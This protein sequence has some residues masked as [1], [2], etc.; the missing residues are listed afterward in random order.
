MSIPSSPSIERI[1]VVIFG[2][3]TTTLIPYILYVA[4]NVA[5]EDEKDKILGVLESYIMRRMVTHATT[6]NYNNLFTSLIL[7]QVLDADSLKNRLSKGTDISTYLPNDDDLLLGFQQSKLSNLQTRGILYLIEAGIRPEKSSTAMLGFNNYSVEHMMPKNWVRNWAPC[8]SQE[9]AKRRD[10]VLLTLGNLAII[11]Q[12]LNASIR[13][14]DWPTKKAGKGPKK[15]GLTLCAAGLC[16][17]SDA[18]KCEAWN[19]G[20][21]NKRALWLFDQAKQLWQV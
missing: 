8:E 13:D 4:K 20:E 9:A 18:L 21:I 16:T 19:E 17:I 3:K 11:P 5:D 15:P 14:G 6:K 2:L 10:S 1:N 12:T 7:N